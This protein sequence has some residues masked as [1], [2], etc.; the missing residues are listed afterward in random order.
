M[1]SMTK[2]IYKNNL[3]KKMGSFQEIEEQMPKAQ[4]TWQCLRKK[5]ILD[6]LMNKRNDKEKK[7]GLLNSITSTEEFHMCMLC[8]S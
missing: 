1:T 6:K 5:T 2:M 8:T 4:K 7:I 3:K